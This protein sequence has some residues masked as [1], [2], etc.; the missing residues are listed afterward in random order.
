[1]RPRMRGAG[2]RP[3]SQICAGRTAVRAWHIIVVAIERVV[4]WGGSDSQWPQ[5][6]VD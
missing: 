3:R 1:M 6:S 5:G 2:T 4:A